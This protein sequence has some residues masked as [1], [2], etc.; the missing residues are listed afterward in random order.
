MKTT[1]L[2]LRLNS[3][4]K[5]ELE[6]LAIVTHRSKSFLATEAI[7]RYLELEAWQISE[8]ESSI[9][10]ADAGDFASTAHLTNL[11]TKYAR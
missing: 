4:T 3:D 6:Q 1:A 7:K 5:K 11:A 9:I 10:E 2:T 8:I